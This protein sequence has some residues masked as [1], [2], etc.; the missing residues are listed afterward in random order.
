MCWT[1]GSG[2]FEGLSRFQHTPGQA[3]GLYDGTV[4]VAHNYHCWRAKREGGCVQVQNHRTCA[5]SG[6][7]SIDVRASAD[8][9]GPQLS[10]PPPSSC[11]LPHAMR[12]STLRRPLD[13]LGVPW[14]S[15]STETRIE[16]ILYRYMARL[17]AL[18]STGTCQS[19]RTT[20]CPN[21]AESAIPSRCS[22]P[23]T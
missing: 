14:P 17:H 12:S 20:V 23:I 10:H 8:A 4:L 11:L 2:G 13:R 21:A 16:S 18:L 19:P 6:S 1:R 3:E 7:I 9:R 15:P 5:D 22:P